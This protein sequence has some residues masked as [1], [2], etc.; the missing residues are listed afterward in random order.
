MIGYSNYIAKFG[1][2]LFDC[3]RQVWSGSCRNG[4]RKKRAGRTWD[5]M[6]EN[7]VRE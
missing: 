1:S 2:N 6:P 7:L 3:R 4:S 5:E